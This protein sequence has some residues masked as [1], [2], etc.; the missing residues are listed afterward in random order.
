MM[1]EAVDF[2]DRIGTVAPLLGLCAFGLAL[3]AAVAFI[4]SRARKTP[5]ERERL[6]RYA[7]NARGR[8]GDAMITDVRGDLLI[9]E[10]T[11][12]GV[13]YS[14]SQDVSALRD[15]LPEDRGVLIGHANLKYH[16]KNPANSIVVCETWSGLRAP[17]RQPARTPSPR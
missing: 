15:L 7:V 9:Y 10:Y 11:V 6:R 2:F 1:R 14:A 13:T 16:P 3:A 5:A 4:V 12:R 17:L 8:M